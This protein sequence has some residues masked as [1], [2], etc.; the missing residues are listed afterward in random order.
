MPLAKLCAPAVCEVKR[1]WTSVHQEHRFIRTSNYS[2]QFFQTHVFPIVDADFLLLMIVLVP[3][4]NIFSVQV[5]SRVDQHGQ[6]L[7]SSRGRRGTGFGAAARTDA[8]PRS[9]GRRPSPARPPSLPGHDRFP[10]AAAPR[11]APGAPGPQNGRCP[12]GPAQR[13]ERGRPERQEGRGTWRREARPRVLL[14]RPVRGFKGKSA[15]SLA[16]LRS[17]SVGQ[18]GRAGCEPSAPH[19]GGTLGCFLP[20]KPRLSCPW[21]EAITWD[22]ALEEKIQK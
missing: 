13:R 18:A 12:A 1:R 3:G 16:A 7:L 9:R 4:K 14:P 22:R 21:N 19:P 20:H 10:P 11:R 5:N 8:G 6:L 17:D 2:S 15:R